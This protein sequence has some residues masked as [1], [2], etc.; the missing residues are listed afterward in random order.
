MQNQTVEQSKSITID[1]N[2]EVADEQLEQTIGTDN[3]AQQFN[4][5]P[6]RRPHRKG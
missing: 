2:K 6:I 5:K 3:R 1:C 4:D